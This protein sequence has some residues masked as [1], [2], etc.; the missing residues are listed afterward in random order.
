MK[1]NGFMS[2]K[3]NIEKL[4]QLMKE[5]KIDAY[6]VA[7]SDPHQSEY[8]ADHF[9]S[10]AF[11]SG[12][13]G[14]A[15][16][17]LAIRD[18]GCYLW[19]D[20]RYFLQAEEQLQGTGIQL[21]RM[22]I[23]GV[24]TLNEF[25]REKLPQGSSVGFDGRT[26]S[27]KQLDSMQAELKERN[28]SY[29]IDEDLMEEVWLERPAMP[30]GQ[31]KVHDLQYAGKTIKEKLE[32]V[33]EQMNKDEIEAY[34]V[35]SLDDIAWLFNIRGTDILF[36]PVV[37]A[38]AYM[39][40]EQTILY[41]DQEKL[42]SQVK[43]HLTSSN[44]I[45]KDYDALWTAVNQLGEGKIVGVDS[46]RVNSKLYNLLKKE[47]AKVIEIKEITRLLKAVKN[48]V[49]IENLRKC[50]IVDNVAMVRFIKWL[51]E[52]VGKEPLTEL[53]VE[54]KLMSLRAEGEN[55]KGVS[56]ET[57][58]GYGPHG[59]IIH[60]RATKES[61][62]DIHPEGFLLV[63]SGGQYL[64][65][66]TDITRTFALGALTEE[67]KKHYTL[68]LR[69]HINLSKLKFPQGTKGVQID[70]LARQP[71]W[72]EGLEY[73]HGTGHGLGF[74]LNVHE[75]PQS[76]SQHLIDQPL[77]EGMV[78]TNEP[79]YYIEGGYGIRLEND[80]LVVKDE[81]T[82]W[83]QFYRFEP[84]TLC[85][86][87]LEAVDAKQMKPEEKQWLNDYHKT[88]YNTLA[89]QLTEEERQWLKEATRSI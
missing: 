11:I 82:E 53:S 5:R 80:V 74:Y 12:F 59:A 47:S 65:G 79:G 55:N 43:E 54:E 31:V 45:I 57:I 29:K 15:G 49:E 9:K 35:A 75:G 76:I 25:I 41:I 14:S 63:D 58:A 8:V 30:K 38:Y 20:G 72:E 85:P 70:I 17:F 19:T 64:G 24:A 18:Q 6:I 48:E 10:R 51:K 46:S 62:S 60:Y 78:I 66:T 22:G 56:F 69:G 52:N 13:T 27:G 36:S 50:N 21:M 16:T 86:F 84:L 33:R 1:G 88:V 28:Y 7:S 61:N 39:D 26:Y 77:L 67:M 83:G 44:V 4:Y 87:D 32:A 42:S 71:L 34:Y 68:V 40:L 73:R 23:P 81:K 89:A 2:V 37:Y 3:E